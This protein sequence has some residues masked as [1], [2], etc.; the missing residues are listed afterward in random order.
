MI[1]S[2]QTIFALNLLD[3]EVE[4]SDYALFALRQR[5]ANNLC[6]TFHVEEK[7][8]R[9]SIFSI[10]GF[11]LLFLSACQSKISPCPQKTGTPSYLTVPPQALPTS[12][13][14]LFTTPVTMEIGGKTILVDKIVEG[15]LCNDTWSGTVYVTCNVQ[16]YDWVDKPTFLKDCALSIA[17][18]TVV[19]VAYHNNAAYYKGCSCHTDENA[20]P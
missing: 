4:K 20:E 15:P 7:I 16:V 3:T 13:P 9:Y 1:I 10:L 12:T 11:L 17:P 18:D 19:Y 14:G 5:Q 8:M 6:A 2:A